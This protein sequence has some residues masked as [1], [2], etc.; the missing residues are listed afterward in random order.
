MARRARVL[1]SIFAAAPA[2]LATYGDEVDAFTARYKLSPKMCLFPHSVFKI[3]FWINFQ[4]RFKTLSFTIYTY[5]YLYVNFEC[6]GLSL[7]L[8]YI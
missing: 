4:I 8:L 6:N 5:S 7:K 2:A 1:I 3:I